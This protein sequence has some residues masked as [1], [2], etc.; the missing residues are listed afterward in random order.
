MYRKGRILFGIIAIA[1]FVGI[2]FT[3]GM[4]AYATI[5]RQINRYMRLRKARIAEQN[6][7]EQ[8]INKEAPQIHTVTLD[9]EPWSLEGQKGRNVLLFFWATSCPYSR[10]AIPYMIDLFDRYNQRDDMVV[11]G[12]SV[13]RDRDLLTCFIT[14]K[15]IPWINL[16]EDG[17]GWDNSVT[18][19][20]G[21]HGIPS[22]WIVDD[23]KSVREA[24]SMLILSA[25]M[26]AK[27]FE[28]PDEFLDYMDPNEKS[29]LIIDVE[30]KGMSGFDFYMELQ[31]K[32][33]KIPTI[34]LTASDSTEYR[35]LAK[36]IGAVGYLSKPV[37]DQ[38]LI[39]SI[40]WAMSKN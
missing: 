25:D 6:Q 38:A 32:G 1:I 7:I 5:R 20:F 26:K 33:I 39:D 14:S 13:D 34:F 15:N 9:G 8:F 31:A 17:K 40:Q 21:V 27:T 22:V 36:R 24:L 30:M 28:K 4:F 2:G 35:Q 23:D 12:I 29:C 18:K 16:F 11:T 19:A 37:D 3:A 10:G